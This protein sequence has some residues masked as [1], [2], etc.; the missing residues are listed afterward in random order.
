MDYQH[1]VDTLRRVNDT[2]LT[3][4]TEYRKAATDPARRNTI[5]RDMHQ[6]AEEF[7]TYFEKSPINSRLLN[8]PLG[9]IQRILEQA[10]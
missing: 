9:K 1:L 8:D 2:L 7:R 4:L 10:N 6:A 3:G 5:K